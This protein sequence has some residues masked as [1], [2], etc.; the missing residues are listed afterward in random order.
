MT[1][2]SLRSSAPAG[3]RADALVVGF[4]EVDGDR[5]YGYTPHGG[6]G[7]AVRTL[8]QFAADRS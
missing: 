7:M 4:H 1:K 2:I 3:L 8:V 6:T 5:A